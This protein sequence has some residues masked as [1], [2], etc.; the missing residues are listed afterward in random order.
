MTEDDIRTIRKRLSEAHLQQR[1]TRM[2]ADLA[3]HCAGMLMALGTARAEADA[4]DA[5]DVARRLWDGPMT[6]FDDY[7][8]EVITALRDAYAA[9]YRASK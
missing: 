1:P 7:L 5:E 4:Y 8:A 6:S 3:S 9:G 2:E